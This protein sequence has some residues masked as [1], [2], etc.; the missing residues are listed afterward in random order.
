M[1]LS[2]LVDTTVGCTNPLFLFQWCAECTFDMV[3]SG[4]RKKGFYPRQPS[5]LREGVTN[6]Y[7]VL[8][9]VC[10]IDILPK[11]AL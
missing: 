8:R 11:T 9:E 5:D 3:S 4:P 7:I 1:S 10:Y 6:A 2:L